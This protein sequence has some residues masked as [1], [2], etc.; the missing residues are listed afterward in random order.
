MKT[1]SSRL[2]M[3]CNPSN[4]PCA[5]VQYASG[6]KIRPDI[7]LVG[8]NDIR[9]RIAC[10]LSVK[11]NSVVLDRYGLSRSRLTTRCVGKSEGRRFFAKILLANPYPIPERFSTL[12][13][14]GRSATIPVRSLF[15]QIETEWNMTLRMQGFSGGHCVPTPMGRSV[16]ARTIVWEK[17]DGSSLAR[18]LKAPCWKPSMAKAGSRAMFQLGVWL[19]GVHQASRFGKERINLRHLIRKSSNSAREI[20]K[21]AQR[22]ELIAWKILERALV[23]IGETPPFEVPV[24]FTH[25]DLC[26]TNL[27]W[28][29]KGWR[30]A[31][32]DY[33]LSGFR[34][35]CHDLFAIIASL[36]SA[37]L[38]PLI[39][40]SVVLAWERSFWLG[41]G[42][43]P[44]RLSVYVRALALARIFYH[45]LLRFHTRR[46]SQGGIAGIEAR[47]YRTFLE[48]SVI[49]KRLE[50]PDFLYVRL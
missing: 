19:R 26:L 8:A 41:Y 49:A 40:K 15:E 35:V 18:V 10:A 37:L 42:P 2:A 45:H 28:D 22:Y 38:N 6:S 39:P 25:G 33:E 32:V 44:S 27:L 1:F 7:N 43:I 20:D 13:Q 46:K 11:T 29:N 48:P 16:P 31:V 17:A 14:C 30:L 36:R 21:T 23:E 3:S 9:E 4:T 24:A 5:E 34:P 50:L 47:V 12:W